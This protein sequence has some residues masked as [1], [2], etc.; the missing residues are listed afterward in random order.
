MSIDW[1]KF[2]E[3]SEMRRSNTRQLDLLLIKH[4]PS[5][6]LNSVSGNTG[7]TE[8]MLSVSVFKKRIPTAEVMTPMVGVAR[9]VA[10][11]K[12]TR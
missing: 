6:L 9:I 12:M 10:C 5:V 4:C 11:E 7:S 1:G 8:E 2:N 3:A